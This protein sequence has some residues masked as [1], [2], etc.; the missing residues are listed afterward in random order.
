MPAVCRKPAKSAANRRSLTHVDR[1]PGRLA[2]RPRSAMA[3]L[4][5]LCFPDPPAYGGQT[6]GRRRRPVRAL[7]DDMI[8]TMYDNDGIGLAATQIDVHERIV[9]VDV[10]ESHDRRRVLINPEITWAAATSRSTPTRVACRCR[11]SS[12]ASN[13]PRQSGDG[14]GRQRSTAR[15]GPKASWPCRSSRRATCSGKVFVGSTQ[16][17]RDD[18]ARRARSAPA[19]TRSLSPPLRVRGRKSLWAG[20]ASYEAAAR[21]RPHI[22]RRPA[23]RAA[24]P[25][26]PQRVF[27]TAARL[28]Y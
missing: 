12:T 14:A 20:A 28:Q 23:R 24:R 18:L 26:Q 5:I 6:G 3:L 8:E 19:P 10:S 27:A 9:V 4:S 13:A 7:V 22:Q 11:A 15:S 25:G 16:P 17:V 1:L 2:A 21:G